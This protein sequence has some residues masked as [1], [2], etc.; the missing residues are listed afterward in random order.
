VQFVSPWLALEVTLPSGNQKR[1]I[2]NADDL[3][4]TQ[5]INEGIFESARRG[6]VTS[7]SMMVNYPAAREAAEELR[8]TDPPPLG[9]GLHVA[10]S[11]GPLAMPPG[12]VPSLV[13]SSKSLPA[14]PDGHGELVFEEVM[15]EVRAQLECF[16]ELMAADPTHLDG[17]HHCHRMPQAFRAVCEVAKEIGCPVRHVDTEML[18]ELVRL[19]VPSTDR[20]VARFY[21]EGVSLPQLHELLRDV[22]AGSTELM[23]HPGRVDEEL[24]AASSYTDLRERELEILTDLSVVSAIHELGIERIDYSDLVVGSSRG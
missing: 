22:T 4:R 13:D 1:L 10:L 18:E 21:G 19:G 12:D 6:I 7:A 9:V 15:L 14:T 20:F 17:H 11:G 16:R 23:C 24:A 3:G 2:I 8:S 5:G